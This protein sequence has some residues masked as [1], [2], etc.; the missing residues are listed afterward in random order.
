MQP[1]NLQQPQQP[2]KKLTMGDVSLVI[3]RNSISTPRGPKLVR[4]ISFTGRRYQDPETGEWKGNSFRPVDLPIVGILCR[5]AQSYID[6]NP[7]LDA[8]GSDESLPLPDHSDSRS[9]V[10]Q[11]D[12][13]SE[14]KSD[15]SF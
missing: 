11:S 2:E 1:N 5:D 3:W 13:R 4:K 6:A 12:G 15:S 10:E 14:G 9:S 7:L 8:Q